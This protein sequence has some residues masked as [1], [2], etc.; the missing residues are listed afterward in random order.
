MQT[1]ST[2]RYSYQAIA[3]FILV[4]R[5]AVPLPALLIHS[6]LANAQ[7]T[8]TMDDARLTSIQT[9]LDAGNFA[10]A[11]QLIQQWIAQD[12]KSAA[13][14]YYLGL[15]AHLQ[16]QLDI[17]IAAYQAAIQLDKTYDPAYINLG[18]AFIELNQFDQATPLF[19]E[20][21]K[22]PDRQQTPLSSH[23]I[24]H[25]NLAIIYKRQGKFPEARTEVQ[26]AL[27]ISPDF[28]QAQ[29]LLKLLP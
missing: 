17:A 21:L 29:E 27:A 8:P 11:E 1:R 19:Q 5:L 3:L 14:Q 15:P 6:P 10:E 18:L 2:P 20:V 22:L 24:A 12:P 16:T 13:A 4:T 25:Y 7:T 28:T 26:A 9:A 23:T